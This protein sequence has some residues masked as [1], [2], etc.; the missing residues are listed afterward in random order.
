MDGSRPH[1]VRGYS[2]SRPNSLASVEGRQESH[3]PL[4]REQGQAARSAMDIL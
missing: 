3:A 4:I 2:G 1:R